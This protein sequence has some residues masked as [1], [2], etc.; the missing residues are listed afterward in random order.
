MFLE[1]TKT[2]QKIGEAIPAHRPSTSMPRSSALVRLNVLTAEVD[3]LKNDMNDMRN[4]LKTYKLGENDEQEQLSSDT[5]E[6]PID[7][8]GGWQAHVSK[9]EKKFDEMEK[10]FSE[11]REQ[12]VQAARTGLVTTD[13]T[14]N[15]NNVSN[16]EIDAINQTIGILKNYMERL[17]ECCDFL[18]NEK[19][20]QNERIETISGDLE[21]MK[22]I[23]A[24]KDDVTV[25][26]MDKADFSQVQKKVSVDQF[27]ATK[28]DLSKNIVE[29]ISKLTEKEENWRKM[30]DE[31]KDLVANKLDKED[32][33]P[34][35]EFINEKIMKLQDRLKTLTA[36]KEQ[37]EA[38]GTRSRFI[39]NL[40]CI[41]CNTDAVMRIDPC[42]AIAKSYKLPSYLKPC[43]TK[44]LDELRLERKLRAASMNLNLNHFE[45]SMKFNSSCLRYCGGSHTK[46]D[47]ISCHNSRGF[48]TRP[49]SA[50]HCHRHHL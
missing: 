11:F 27:D 44:K 38:A 21:N 19:D 20:M 4:V 10:N 8:S 46:F 30:I 50:G 12:Y 23:K 47:H 26:L 9:L 16:T 14:T 42:P 31:L 13:S 49:Q 39:K 1:G 24:D 18:L 17:Q 41:S 15:E 37:A 2:S 3:G 32:V 33:A 25:A 6:K 7:T 34:L 40:N 35:K 48:L 22:S 28:R 45:E 43:L 29:L 5:G 36:L